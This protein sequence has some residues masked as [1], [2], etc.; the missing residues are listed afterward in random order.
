[1]NAAAETTSNGVTCPTNVVTLL[2]RKVTPELADTVS[3]DPKGQV[4]F[5]AVAYPPAPA[6]GPVR[7]SLE[8]ARDGL[9][10]MR[11]PSSELPLG[12][13][14]TVTALASLPASKLPPGQYDARVTFRYGGQQVTGD[15][16]F[17][18]LAAE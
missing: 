1:M 7:M 3:P 14:G 8:I 15:T 16:P 12:P 10:V 6:E 11:S 9:P 5:Y 13:G 18:V 4:T 2:P 17:A